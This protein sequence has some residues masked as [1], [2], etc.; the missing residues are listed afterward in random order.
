MLYHDRIEFYQAID[1]NKTSE[2]N[3]CDICHCWYFLDK[4]SK[5][6]L[7]VCHGCH[8]VLMMPMIL[9]NIAIKNIHVAYYSFI[10]SGI[11]KNE[12]INLV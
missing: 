1:V 4:G 8:D 3:K 2:S 11:S 10:I 7:D 12:G 6:Q 9:S 5:F